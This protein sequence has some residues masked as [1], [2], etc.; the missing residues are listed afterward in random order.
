[1]RHRLLADAIAV[2]TLALLAA[3]EVAYYAV[4]TSAGVWAVAVEQLAGGTLPFVLS[5]GGVG[6]LL[7]RRLPTNAIGWSFAVG[8]LL[9]SVGA[10]GD[11]YYAVALERQS[12]LGPLT[13]I[14]ANISLHSWIFAMPFSIQLPLQLLPNG[15]LLSRRWRPVL[16]LIGTGVVVGSFGFTT[17][18]G[19]IDG[20]DPALQLIN[21]LGLRAAGPVPEVL[22]LTGAGML[23]VGILAGAVAV[24]LRFRRSHGVERQQMRWV[25][26]GGCCVVFAPVSALV[27][28][29]PDVVDGII[30]T[31]CIAAVPVC[32]GVA[33]LR[34]RLYDLGRI[35]SRTLSYAVVTALLVAVYLAVVTTTARLAP[36]SSSLAVAASTLAAAALFQPLRRR[37]QSA[38]DHRFNRARY[39]ADRTVDE[40]RRRL[41]DEVDLDTVRTDLLEVVEGTVQPSSVGLWL[42][43]GA[44]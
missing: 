9:W 25:A 17:I 15:R 20:T 33:V 4:N 35:V 18:P 24:V 40:F 29:L 28:E 3:A 7:A 44:R 12:E 36:G 21:P 14:A 1:M 10:A 23:L 41:R 13:R 16:W 19:V 42:R 8:G 34:Y 38:V 32:V 30:G 27:P 11:A 26:A 5:F 31:A 6:W 37:V 22:A 39:D 2:L 43:E